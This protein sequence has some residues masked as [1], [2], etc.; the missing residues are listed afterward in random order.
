MTK[1][2]INFLIKIN[3][4]PNSQLDI[5]EDRVADY[6]EI[7]GFDENYNPTAEGKICESILDYISKQ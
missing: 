6:L 4:D 1:E 7:Y 3:V 2:Q 5:I